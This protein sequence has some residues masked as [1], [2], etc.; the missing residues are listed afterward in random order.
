[1]MPRTVWYPGHMEKGKKRL[2]ELSSQVDVFVEVRDARAPKSSSSPLIHDLVKLKPVCVVLSKK[3]LAEEDKTKLWID[4]LSSAGM[5][6]FAANLR[7]GIPGSLRGK[8]FELS[9][10]KP[11]WREL[12]VAIVGIPNVG[13][14]M[15]LNALIGKKAS[16]VGG[17][18]GITK[19]VSWYR[20]DKLLVLDSP[21][22]LDPKSDRQTN[23]V[24][25][26]IGCVRVDVIGDYETLSLQ[27]L[28]FIRS[29]GLMSRLLGKLPIASGEE[30][31]AEEC[32][33]AVGRYIG[34][35]LP[36]GK[37]DLER[38]G[39]FLLESFATGK[40]GPFTLELP[41]RCSS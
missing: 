7:K 35:L 14:S 20:S 3:D 19:G 36:G 6:A 22:I 10:D 38:A 33:E 34:A 18:P 5:P 27:F 32:L 4:E 29:L 30:I 25:A 11:K 13:K 9:R 39:R 31:K 21:G 2:R 28:E 12:R 8:L 16:K 1:M 17:I 40:L 41:Q 37:V 23:M 26:W 24:L 15:L